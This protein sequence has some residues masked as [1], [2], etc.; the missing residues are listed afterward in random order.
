MRC[1]TSAPSTAWP[2]SRTTRTACSGS[3]GGST[4]RCGRWTPDVLYL[5]SFSK[6]FASGPAGRL[7]AGAARGAR[8]AGA[9]RRVGHAVPA[10][11]QPDAGVALPRRRTTG[12]AR[13]RRSPR[14]TGS[15][16]TRCSRAL[17]T[18]LP[19][20]S[21]WN[22]PDGG[23]YVWLTVP[24]GVDTKAMLPRAVTARVAYASGTGFYADGFGSRQLRLSYCYPTPGAD[25]RGRATA[26]R[27]AGGG[28]G[29]HAHVRQ[30]GA[31][32]AV[33]PGS[34]GPLAGHHLS[35]PAT[36]TPRDAHANTPRSRA[37]SERATR[38]VT[39]RT[40]AVLAGG[41]SHEREVSL[42]SGRRLAA[43]LRGVGMAVREW[44]AD[45]ALIERL[46][47]DRP[48]AVV[49]ALHGGE[50]ENGSVQA[51]LEL[52][53][54]A[55]RRDAGAGLP[56][57][58]GQADREGRAGPRRARHPGL[59]GAAARDLPRAGR[60]GGARRDGGAARAA[61]DAQAGPGRL[62]AR[63]PGGRRGRGPARGDGELPGL[64]RHRAGR[65]VRPGHRGGGVGGGRRRRSRARC[66][67]SRSRRRAA[68]TTTPRATPRA[69]PPSTA[70]PGWTT[71]C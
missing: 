23:F 66:R 44:D 51:V 50:G 69:R 15:G 7:G 13:S 28:A 40:V 31:A 43:A 49:V 56:A 47:T 4:R 58:V 12:A 8:P 5:G 24:E 19:D 62:G 60:P 41:L 48:D 18:Y 46:R 61:A 9:G 22:I 55:V 63:C 30:R 11:L 27:R 37:A 65:A 64:R 38:A 33:D 1:S 39:E 2:S 52:L 42:R 68:S 59:G 10:D 14:S 20:G 57:G 29:R 45:A 53:G 71:P 21:T 16:A 6:T 25:H 70:R 34:A 36:M 35:R 67:R 26:G 32:P 3:P 54:R 17:E